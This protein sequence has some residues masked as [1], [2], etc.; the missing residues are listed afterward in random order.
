MPTALLIDVDN[1]LD[2][3]GKF[4]FPVNPIQPRGF[5]KL[6]PVSRFNTLSGSGGVQ[7]AKDHFPP[8]TFEW[9]SMTESE[10]S[11]TRIAL[12]DRRYIDTGLEYFIGID[13]GDSTDK[14]WPFPTG[15]VKFVKVRILN[16]TSYENPID[17]NID[18]VIYN[19]R[20]TALWV[21]AP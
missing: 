20:M 18:E 7:M 5:S 2:S 10:Y 11:T 3:G 12:E 4:L 9:P 6:K 15:A 14:G 8:V 19:L 21:D 17:N 1:T 13:V 16:V